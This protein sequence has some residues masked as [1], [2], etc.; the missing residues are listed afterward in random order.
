MLQAGP[1]VV[2]CRSLRVIATSAVQSTSHCFPLIMT[3]QLLL[4]IDK[5][6]VSED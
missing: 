4:S 6:D 1:N 5:P 3:L 2:T